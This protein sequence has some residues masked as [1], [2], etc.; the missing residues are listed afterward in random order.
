MSGVL[1]LE[2][3]I[4]LLATD[5][6]GNLEDY[7]R[8]KAIFHEMR[9]RGEAQR[10]VLMGDLVH[11]Y[12]SEPHPDGSKEILDDLIDNPDPR[13]I[14]LLGNHELMHIYG[15]YNVS[16]L[17]QLFVPELEA[18]FGK[19]KKKYH[20]FMKSMPYAVRTKGGVLINHP[21]PSAAVTGIPQ[22]D[23]MSLLT[24]T[25]GIS[26]MQNLDHDAI[27]K[28]ARA[29]G[30]GDEC[31]GFHETPEGAYLWEVFF[32]KNE[33]EYPG[34]MYKIILNCF[35]MIMSRGYEKQNFLVSGHIPE[36]EGH[37]VLHDKQLRLCSSYGADKDKKTISI[38]DAGRK[39]ESIQELVDDLRPLE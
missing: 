35:L 26:F 15:M 34:R 30:N 3:G 4:L 19:D 20:A 31:L 17:G 9:G 38:V 12:N 29:A 16:K 24:Q 37:R 32:N 27:L 25:D 23:Y 14:P 18:L 5:L 10:L 39:Y 2:G 21:G 6:H 1:D 7:Q 8:V 28:K 22:Q 13:I 11:R 36:Q 33:A